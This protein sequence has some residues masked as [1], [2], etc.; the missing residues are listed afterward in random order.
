MTL[1]ELLDEIK[2]L[3]SDANLKLQANIISILDEAVVKIINAKESG[4]ETE[5]LLKDAKA[6]KSFI[7]H[8]LAYRLYLD[9][10]K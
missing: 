1:I 8:V 9:S 10:V 3:Y 6:I 5:E 7:P 4:K 2:D